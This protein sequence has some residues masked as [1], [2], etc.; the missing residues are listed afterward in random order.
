MV[1]LRQ[2]IGK[3][4]LR[5]KP[6]TDT[7]KTKKNEKISGSELRQTIRQLREYI[8]QHPQKI[9]N[10]TQ[11]ELK[12]LLLAVQ[13]SKYGGQGSQVKQW[14]SSIEQG[15]SSSADLVQIVSFLSG[16]DSL[17]ILIQTTRILFRLCKPSRDRKEILPK[18]ERGKSKPKSVKYV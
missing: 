9:D 11:D 18:K 8:Q 2:K 13:N 14:L 7:T 5:R 15:L 4:V 3:S 1:K 16:I 17:P 6:K 10:R 12:Q